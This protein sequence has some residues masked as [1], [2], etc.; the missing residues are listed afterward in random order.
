VI[1]D[2]YTRRLGSFCMDVNVSM[3]HDFKR[4]KVDM[5]LIIETNRPLVIGIG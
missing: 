5:R 3:R 1:S 2:Q 4:I